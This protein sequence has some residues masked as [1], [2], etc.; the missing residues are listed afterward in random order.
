M[1]F[2]DTL[3]CFTTALL[4]ALAAGLLSGAVAAATVV[5]DVRLWRAPDY[6]RVVLDLSAPVSHNVISLE[7]PGRIVIDIENS[8]LEVDTDAL[9]FSDSPVLRLR[10]GVKNQSDLRIVLDLAKAVKPSSF[11]LKSNK[12]SGDRLVIDLY[13]KGKRKPLLKYD[14]NSG[15]RDIVIAIDAGHGGEDP[16]ASGPNKLRE[17]KVV[18]AIAKELAKLFKREPGYK[19]VLIRSGD[20]FV[21]LQNRRQLAKAAQADLMGSVHAD[22]FS[23]SRVNGTSVYVLSRRGASSAT[24][25]FL[26]SEANSSDLIGGVRLADK[27]N[28]LVSILT[29]LAMTSS[30]GMSFQVGGKVINAMGGVSK[31]HSKKVEQANF[32][33]LRSPYMPSILVETGFIS[34]PAEA[35]KLNT[36]RYQRQ[37]AKAIFSGVSQHFAANPPPDTL[38][39]WQRKNRQQAVEYTIARGDTLSAIALRFRVSVAA[40]RSKNAL[41]SN[42][43]KIGQR[44]KIPAS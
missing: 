4:V 38:L 44:I 40:I 35:K 33:V 1:R 37:M 24:A 15:R 7:N 30:L 19:P 18:L 5:N 28:E 20:Y 27:S 29:D 39:A 36:K 25:K 32:S 10:S 13:D 31:L 2:R 8:R 26:A 3:T 42:T 12:M 34:N 23:D 41:A 22:A 9:D 6:T 11:L 16:G 14:N 43:V 17:K 21:S